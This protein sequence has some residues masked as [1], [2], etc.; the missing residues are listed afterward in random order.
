[1]LLA[2]FRMAGWCTYHWWEYSWAFTALKLGAPEELPRC[3]EITILDAL[4]LLGP[5]TSPSALR[6][7][8]VNINAEIAGVE[9]RLPRAN[10]LE[11]DMN[12]VT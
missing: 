8:L 9:S 12:T 7:Q 5:T 3:T 11:E 1:M 6:S 4:F 10:Y 2:D